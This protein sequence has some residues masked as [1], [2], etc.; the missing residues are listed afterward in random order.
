MRRLSFISC[1]LALAGCT[2]YSPD[3]IRSDIGRGD[4]TGVEAKLLPY[5][6]RGDAEAFNAMGVV[7][8]DCRH[9]R[10]MAVKY[11]IVAA[12]MGND[13]ARMNL[14]RLGESVPAADLVRQSDPNE[15][16]RTLLLI[17]AFQPRQ[18]FTPIQAPTNCTSRSVGGAIQ[19]T[20]Y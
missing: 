9:D 4:C 2:S 20:C 1:A 19:T 16:A 12:R 10:Q 11:Y 6:R 13:T 7:A 14:T 8:M 17:Q 18:T 15:L 5:A 3:E